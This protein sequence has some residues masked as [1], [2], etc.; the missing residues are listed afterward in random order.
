MS[1]QRFTGFSDCLPR[2]LLYGIP[3]HSLEKCLFPVLVYLDKYLYNQ[4]VQIAPL[5]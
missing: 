1:E 5:I 2:G 3:A 4:D